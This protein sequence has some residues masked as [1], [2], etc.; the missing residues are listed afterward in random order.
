MYLCYINRL[1][2]ETASTYEGSLLA[3]TKLAF[4]WARN[5][6]IEIRGREKIFYTINNI[7]LITLNEFL[8]ER[9]YMRITINHVFFNINAN[10]C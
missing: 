7:F 10:V 5:D 3:S 4:Q 6:L 9:V 1:L 8:P 2:I